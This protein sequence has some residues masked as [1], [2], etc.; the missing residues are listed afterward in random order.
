MARR[1]RGKPRCAAAHGGGPRVRRLETIE[2]LQHRAWLGPLLVSALPRERGKSAIIW[3]RC[4]PA[5]VTRNIAA[6]VGII[7]RVRLIV[8][9][10]AIEAMANSK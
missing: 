1:S 10:Q 5:F 7:S 8:F 6:P 2:P 4:T 3:R 9:A